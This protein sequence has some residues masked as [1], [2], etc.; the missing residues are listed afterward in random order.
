MYKQ[1]G[2]LP[3]WELAS[4]ETD[5]M[6][7][8]H[9]VSVITDAAIK[10][11]ND[12]DKDL[13]LEA[14]VK[15]ATW[16]H[17]GLP[18]YQ[19]HGVITIDDDHE[20]VSKTLEYAYDDW[21]IAQFANLLGNEQIAEIFTKRSLSYR[22]AFDPTTGFMR[23]K[24]NGGWLSPFEPREVNNNF[25][26]AN[27][28]QYSFFVP[29]DLAGHMKL[30]GG[31]ASYERKLD[32]LFST[33]SETTGRDQVDI[34]GLIGQYA[35]GNE[36]S[37]HMAYLYNYVGKS[38]KTQALIRKILNELYHAAPDGLSGN[39]DCG[40]MSAWYVLSSLGI[41]QVC[42]GKPEFVIGSP[43][44]EK[45]IIH[46]ENGNKLEL[47]ANNNSA[48]NIYIQSASL[49]NTALK[50]LSVSYDQLLNLGADD[51]EGFFVG[52]LTSLIISSPTLMSPEIT[53]V[54]LPSLMPVSII[55]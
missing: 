3:V 54:N 37:H 49:N 26:E 19:E 7:G 22:N 29:H 10:G 30:L 8:Y 52:S 20:S 47:T 28:W 48:Q 42:P 6:I 36:P 13:A 21:C 35:H 16:N 34:T 39:E 55:T 27:S 25:T 44:F 14:M 45:S 50:N 2:R 32:E 31:P 12:F 5:C 4:N 11:I 51:G 33:N 43:L 46:F 41:Y 15:S 23:P 9:S 1:G 17:L 53:S 40:Q 18:A 38:N 24:K